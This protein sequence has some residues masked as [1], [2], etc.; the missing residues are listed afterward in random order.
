MSSIM[1]ATE[2]G[3]AVSITGITILPDESARVSFSLGS[4]EGG[5]TEFS[6]VLCDVPLSQS[7]HDTALQACQEFIQQQM[8]IHTLTRSLTY[9]LHKLVED[10]NHSVER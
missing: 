6:V 7:A 2:G 5:F 10:V 9:E 4:E 1:E 8:R 3:Y